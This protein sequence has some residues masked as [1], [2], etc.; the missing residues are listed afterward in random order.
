MCDDVTQNELLKSTKTVKLVKIYKICPKPT[1]TRLSVTHGRAQYFDG[2]EELAF[3][4][5]SLKHRDVGFMCC[6]C[7]QETKCPGGFDERSGNYRHIGLPSQSR[8]CG[9]AFSLAIQFEN[10]I[11]R[12]WSVSDR[13]AVIQLRI[14]NNSIVTIINVYGPTSQRVNNNNAEQDEF[15]A[16]LAR[17]SSHRVTHLVHCST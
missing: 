4:S 16:E 10:Q 5:H 13:I 12:Y 6:I 15:Y 14:S 9:L 2:P 8:H 1:S 3:L 7:L 17:R 11:V